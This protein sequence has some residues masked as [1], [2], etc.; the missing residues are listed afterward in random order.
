MTGA[1]S[2]TIALPS[3]LWGCLAGA[4]VPGPAALTVPV[5]PV[6]PVAPVSSRLPVNGLV[7]ALTTLAR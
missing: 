1:R 4:A 3:Q 6:A 5:A 7:V 2:R